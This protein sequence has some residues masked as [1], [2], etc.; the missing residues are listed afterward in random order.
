MTGF[1]M[2]RLQLVLIHRSS[3]QQGMVET[4]LR[5]ALV[6]LLFI[7]HHHHGKHLGM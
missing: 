3:H 5:A 4:M 2:W 6:I 1:L 7:H